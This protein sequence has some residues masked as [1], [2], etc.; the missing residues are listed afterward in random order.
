LG[1]FAGRVLNLTLG[2][3]TM[4]LFGKVPQSRQIL[5]LVIV[6]GSLLWVALVIGV[7][8]PEVGTFLVALA[9][10]PEFI[11]EN[12]VR[13][14][15][16]IGAIITPFLI[17]IA[18]AIVS[19]GNQDRS[20]I[21]LIK[22]GLRG[23]PFAAVLVV[24]LGVLLV[25]GVVRKV[26]SLVQ[27]WEDAHVPIMVKPGKYEV[28]LANVEETLDLA[29]LDMTARDAG[30]FLSGPPKLLDR[31]AGRGLGDLVPDRLMILGGEGIEVL[32]YPSDLAISGT[33]ER[34]A[35]ARA[36]LAS[37]VAKAPA[38]LTISAEA[39]DLEDRLDRIRD[40]STRVPPVVTIQRLADVDDE[41]A[42]L[43]IPYDEWQIL[44]RLR[45]QL[46]RDAR[47]AMDGK[48]E[49]DFIDEA[50]LAQSRSTSPLG[51]ALGAA[52]VGLVALDVALILA[53]RR[54]EK[55]GQRR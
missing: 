54:A 6:F 43:A 29:G 39:Q 53:S 52:G 9:P 18:G 44:Y 19:T 16:L 24:I 31:I 42:R 7:F 4:L 36:A 10:L 12:W 30:V 51:L 13:L 41:L 15:M 47:R 33:K 45:L 37:R 20:P 46:E 38:Y 21:R 34:V 55:G 8:V 17:G 14:A 50:Q 32:V 2:W 28:V 25:V 49:A 35:R 22:A 40:D 5:L 23:Y 11:D 1:R 48:T 3:A 27:R 26:R